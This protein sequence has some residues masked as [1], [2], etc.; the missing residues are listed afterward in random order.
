MFEGKNGRAGMILPP[1][2]EIYAL[3]EFEEGVGGRDKLVAHLNHSALTKEQEYLVGMIADPAN[4]K[5]S[6]ATI[7]KMAK[8]P[9]GQLI[10]F[11]TEAGFVRA[12]LAAFEKVWGN[13]PE[14]AGDVMEKAVPRTVECGPCH[15]SGR[16][17]YEVK[18]EGW[19]KGDSVGEEEKDCWN[20]FGKKTVLLEPDHEVQKTA[21]ELGG[22][23]KRG[24][25]QV[26]VQVGVQQN[27]QTVLGADFLRD[28]RGATDKIL[29][30]SRRGE[31]PEEQPE[32]SSEE[33]PDPQERDRDEQIDDAE[34][35]EAGDAPG[36]AAVVPPIED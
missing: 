31:Q 30:P 15:G 14:V 36:S 34:I 4:A 16:M 18:P 21:L 33:S 11:F 2:T 20:C 12:Q 23:L 28:F 17:V 9:F 26:G 25:V 6:L 7:A 27:N 3:R 29:F 19:K 22:L 10:K 1:R 24:G 5:K 8:V 13:L 32:E 35:V